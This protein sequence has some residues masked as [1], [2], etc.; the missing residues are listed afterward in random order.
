MHYDY[1]EIATNEPLDVALA[2]LL[3][4]REALTGHQRRTAFG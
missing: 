1:Q 4:A 3:Q 2:T